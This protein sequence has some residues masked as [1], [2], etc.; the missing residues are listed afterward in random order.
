MFKLNPTLQTV[1][2]GEQDVVVLYRSVSGAT[3]LPAGMKNLPSEG[4]ICGVRENSGVAVYIALLETS[5]K[6]TFIYT[7]P[8]GPCG[9]DSYDGALAEAVNFM[10]ALGFKM[11]R[12]NLDYS[13][14]LR[15]VIVRTVR[16][17][18]PPRE[19]RKSVQ[20]KGAPV[21]RGGVGTPAKRPVE[22]ADKERE[23]LLAEKA[24]AERRA[25]AEAE[26]ARHALKKAESDRAEHDKLLLEKAEA[27]KR[28]D[29]KAGTARRLREKADAERLEWDSLL[30]EKAAA[31]LRASHQAEAAQHALNKLEAERCERERLLAAKAEVEQREAELVE[32]TRLKLEKA[33]TE[34]AETEL[35]LD[36]SRALETAA[37]AS[38]EKFRQALD[39]AE[40]ERS[41]AEEILVQKAI[42]EQ[43]AVELIDAAR[44]A[45]EKAEAERVEYEQ[46]LTSK[47]AAEKLAEEQAEESRLALEQA[48]ALRAER[49]KQLAGLITAE[50]AAYEQVEQAQ[51][52]WEYAE[53]KRS[54]NERLFAEESGAGVA[55]SEMFGAVS[56]ALE[57][58]VNE[59][60]VRRSKDEGPAV[61]QRES[62]TFKPELDLKSILTPA[63]VSGPDAGESSPFSNSFQCDQGISFSFDRS[64]TVINIDRGGIIRE[65]YSSS[66]MA[67]VTMENFPAQNCTA[68]LFVIENSGTFA[69]YVSFMLAESRKVLVYLPDKQP[70]L[71]EECGEIVREGIGFIETVGLIMDRVDLGE[72]GHT[73]AFELLPA[74]RRV[75]CFT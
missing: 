35:I 66:N 73:K 15:E 75:V 45:W 28:A 42:A 5:T 33:E 11:E 65:L 6:T 32:A 44:S 63:K 59:H 46:L 48:A 14:A 71:F 1:E 69:V 9:D 27:E 2:A 55:G 57:Q 21:R 17:I 58:A 29:D 40:S 25:S 8:E 7:D 72:E 47:I 60:A 34:R 26:A 30:A 54:E 52:A 18:S 56:H 39:E 74:L 22:T 49:E 10:E 19:A 50:K 36:E 64:L 31:E 67:R 24:E 70:E 13:R 62:D 23:K 20:G 43:R 53:A 41:A 38:M 51:R 37:A 4:F 61:P 12:I 3:A 16:V 68:F